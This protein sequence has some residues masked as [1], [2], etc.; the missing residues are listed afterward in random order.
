MQKLGRQRRGSAAVGCASKFLP[1]LEAIRIPALLC[2]VI[3]VRI[4][5]CVQQSGAGVIGQP[6]VAVLPQHLHQLRLIFRDAGYVMAHVAAVQLLQE[7]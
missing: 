7:C 5:E 2:S 1:L 4:G 3:R 6:P